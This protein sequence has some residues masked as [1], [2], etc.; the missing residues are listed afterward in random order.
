MYTYIVTY[1]IFKEEL[2]KI[3]EIDE[4]IEDYEILEEI[5]TEQLADTLDYCGEYDI[6]ITNI[7]P[8]EGNYTNKELN[9]CIED[10]KLC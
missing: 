8:F 9:N 7:E 1:K 4:A 3:I 10:N 5:L 2:Q 6:Y